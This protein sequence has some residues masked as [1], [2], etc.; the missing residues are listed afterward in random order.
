MI[1]KISF[2]SSVATLILF[3]FYFI[4]RIITILSTKRIWK[5]K[6]I[7]GNSDYS[8]YEVIDDVVLG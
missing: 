3:V 1:D 4:G 8:E 2:L 6:V 7:I 5:D